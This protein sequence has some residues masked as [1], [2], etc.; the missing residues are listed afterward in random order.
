VKL[1]ECHKFYQLL[2]EHPRAMDTEQ[3][4]FFSL[5]LLK[6]LLSA[7]HSD[8]LDQSPFSKP[9]SSVMDISVFHLNTCEEKLEK[10]LSENQCKGHDTSTVMHDSAIPVPVTVLSGSVPHPIRIPCLIPHQ[11][12]V[13]L[14]LINLIVK[15]IVTRN[16][17]IT[18]LVS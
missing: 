9:H 7:V 6:G 2:R 15:E 17:S 10:I 3:N 11:N 13:T 18:Y 8:L 16:I 1:L 12:F 14:I 4:V 5:H